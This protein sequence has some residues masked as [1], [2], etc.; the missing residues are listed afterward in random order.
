[1]GAV[2]RLDMVAL[3]VQRYVA[4]GDGVAIDVQRADARGNVFAISFCLFY[5]A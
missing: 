2:A 4:K 1:M 5:L 3:Q